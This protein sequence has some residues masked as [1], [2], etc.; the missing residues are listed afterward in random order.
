M[1]D[2]IPNTNNH[3]NAV[4]FVPGDLWSDLQRAG[5]W[6]QLRQGGGDPY[7][8]RN[9]LTGRHVWTGEKTTTT[10]AAANKKEKSEQQYVHDLVDNN[11]NDNDSNS[12]SKKKNDTNFFVQ[13]TR[14]WTYSINVTRKQLLLQ[15]SVCNNDNECMINNNSNNKN[16]TI[17]STKT[18]WLLVLEG[19]KMGAVVLWNDK[20]L[21]TV[22]DQFVR[23]IFVLPEDDD[24]NNENVDSSSLL[25]IR[26]DPNI[27]T[28]GR[29]MACSGGWDWAPYTHVVDSGP[30]RGS[31]FV[32]TLG[33]TG[34][35]YL[36]PVQYVYIQ[37]VV[38]HVYYMGDY[39]PMQPITTT[40]LPQEQDR[41][42][43]M[44]SSFQVQVKVYVQTVRDP[45][46]EEHWFVGVSTDFG[47]N[48]T[49]R[50]P[51]VFT[52]SS[53]SS[54]QEQIICVNFTVPL[55]DIQLWWPNN[56]GQQ[57]LYHVR[58]SLLQQRQG[59]MTM[60][61]YNNNS[62]KDGDEDADT[63]SFSTSYTPIIQKR[64]GFRIVQLVT[65][66]NSS[67]ITDLRQ[68][69]GRTGMFFRINGAVVYCR[70]ANVIPMDLLEGRWSD[71]AHRIMVQSAASANMNMLRVWGGGAVLPQSFYDA[72]DE[73][74]I[75][76]YHDLMFVGE[77]NHSAVRTNVVKD[78][79][80]HI[81]RKLSSHP[82]IVLWSGCNECTYFGGS[83]DI[84][85]SFVMTTVSQEDDSR[86]IW[87]GSPSN[88]GWETGVDTLTGRPNGSALRSRNNSSHLLEV[89]GPYHHGY[90]KTY[91][92]V[93]GLLTNY[94]LFTTNIPPRFKQEAVS[95]DIPNTFVSEFGASVS[96]SFES[97]SAMLPREA[98]SLHGGTK[99]DKCY[100]L[101]GVCNICVGSNP[102][103]ERYV[104]MLQKIHGS[105]LF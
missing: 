4:V 103:A 105:L 90:S 96:S 46:K 49:R 16:S 37:D 80:L 66:S 95:P 93:N 84:Y 6:L 73:Y 24:D 42:L 83:M 31:S 92:G 58:V 63:A 3:K 32:G 28:D 26:F 19:I 15:P 44:D 72:C 27:S 33:L 67:N 56:M 55:K 70:G 100:Q 52:S 13:R 29:F 43:R 82:S 59:A 22:T 57:P 21:G 17:T 71:E 35:V 104:S 79:I 50:V 8:N 76:L 20:P 51:I 48:E 98:W 36:V 87:P 45:S 14:T 62:Y 77:Q 12:N 30:H 23:T 64:I 18:T 69:S 5:C 41:I 89:H 78:E 86:A 2:I 7:Y 68:G 102:M 88:Y 61:S 91:P 94:T 39:Y 10:T 97:M 11:V 60:T 40:I 74:G 75:L 25:A 101:Y 99:P 65:T 53:S 81:V 38:C 34:P 1:I 54:Q 85:D 47:K 9:W